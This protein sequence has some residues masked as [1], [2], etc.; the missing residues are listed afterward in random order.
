M[1]I[2]FKSSITLGQIF[3]QNDDFR[4]LS[5][6]DVVLQVNSSS[7]LLSSKGTAT[8]SH[9]TGSSGLNTNSL[10]QATSGKISF[11]IGTQTRAYLQ[12]G[13]V[14]LG[15]SGDNAYLTLD[16]SNGVKLYSG[17]DQKIQVYHGPN[18]PIE[19]DQREVK[20]GSGTQSLD[21]RHTMLYLNGTLGTAGQV[22]SSSGTAAVCE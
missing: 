21:L 9:D 20:L 4:M 7:S 16:N 5:D 6:G 10:I 11:I 14:Q 1:A 8:L 12:S 13:H 18:I 19:I 3:A 17:P 2:P 22:I 15:Y